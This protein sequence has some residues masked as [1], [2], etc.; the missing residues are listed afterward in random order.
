MF[1][2]IQLQNM[3]ISYDSRRKNESQNELEHQLVTVLLDICCFGI[4]LIAEDILLVVLLF[5]N[6]FIFRRGEAMGL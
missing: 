2:S 1:I 4:Q 6:H 3:E 5:S